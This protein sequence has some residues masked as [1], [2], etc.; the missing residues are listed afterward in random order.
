MEMNFTSLKKLNPKK[1][2][3]DYSVNFELFFKLIHI[4]NMV[5]TYLAP[6][7]CSQLLLIIK[8]YK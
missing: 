7:M 3:S 1:K 6:Y 5:S 8:L 4:I 2:S